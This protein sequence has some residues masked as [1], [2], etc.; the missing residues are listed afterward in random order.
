[1]GGLVP[2]KT[3]NTEQPKAHYLRTGSFI[4]GKKALPIGSSLQNTNQLLMK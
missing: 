2:D 1:M 4:K 3:G